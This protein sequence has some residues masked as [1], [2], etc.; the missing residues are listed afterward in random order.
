MNELNSRL[1][2]AEE[3]ISKLKYAKEENVQNETRD[4]KEEIQTIE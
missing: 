3:K 1:H 4:L 2:R